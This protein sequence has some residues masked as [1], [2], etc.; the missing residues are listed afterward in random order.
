MANLVALQT[1][2]QA[3]LDPLL[4][5]VVASESHTADPSAHPWSTGLPL[6]WG[7]SPTLISYV[8]RL[9]SQGHQ[10]PQTGIQALLTAW[11][12]PREA[13]PE[14]LP[15]LIKAYTRADP[16]PPGQ[17]LFVPTPTALG[18]WLWAFTAAP[19]E[20]TDL[21]AGSP[22]PTRP[23]PAIR[24]PPKSAPLAARLQL[25]PLA[26]VQYTHMRCHQLAHSPLT[27]HPEP[28]TALP[29]VPWLDQLAP[30]TAASRQVIRRL[31]K[32][33]DQMALSRPSDGE[34]WSQTAQTQILRSG[35]Q[36]CEAADL[37]LGEVRLA[38]LEA[39]TI[40]LLQGVERGLKHL[41]LTWLQSPAPDR[42]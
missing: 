18:G 4:T 11:R 41:L 32:L 12:S 29:P 25:S 17:I 1:T 40:A 35:Y 20:M 36:L 13:H 15:A 28:G 10:S 38:T 33:V 8:L 42:L 7:R 21:G 37:W 6:R 24:L 22:P 16:L 3:A 39:G 26:L 30:T 9:P 31:V 2:L 27:I 14:H 23:F 5:A 19:V 34:A